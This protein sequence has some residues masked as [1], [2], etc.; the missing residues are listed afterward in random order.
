[1]H[2]HHAIDVRNLSSRR[3]WEILGGT[4]TERCRS[5]RVSA[6]AAA[7]RAELAARRQDAPARRF[8]APR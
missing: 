4:E 3:L 2:D 7:A 5:A 6:L 8:R 1:M